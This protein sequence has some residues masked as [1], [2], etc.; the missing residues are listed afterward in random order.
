[1]SY[2]KRYAEYERTGKHRAARARRMRKIV[3]TAFFSICAV[4]IGCVIY[5][6]LS[7]V[8]VNKALLD[9]KRNCIMEN[10]KAAIDSYSKAIEL[11]SG[12]V[13]AYSNMANAYLSIDDKESAK[14]VLYEGWERTDN[15]ALLSNYRAVILNE[16]VADMNAKKTSLDTVSTILDVLESDKTNKDA[17]EL[18]YQ[19]YPRLCL[20]ASGDADTVFM[21]KLST[22]GKSDER[23]SSFTKYEELINRMVAVYEASPDERLREAITEY[24]I[25]WEDSFT[26]SISDVDSYIELLKKAESALG[27]TNEE[28]KS[29]KAC[30]DN[31][32]EVLGIFDDIF[33]QLDVGNVDELRNFIVSD[34][35]IKL[36]DLF[37]NKGETPQENTVYVPISR[38][39][40]VLNCKDGA[41]SYRFLNFEENPTTRG[42]ITVWANFFEDD[43]V[44]RNAI[45]YEPAAVGKDIYPHTKYSVTYLRSYITSGR[46]T[47]VAKMNYRLETEIEYKDGTVDKTIVGDWGGS[48]EWEMDIDTIESRIRA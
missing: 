1:M 5:S 13:S 48:D 25:P 17:I 20:N 14:K 26:M 3:L 22:E 35:Y 32:K 44:Q 30:L 31:S 8:Q 38:E 43:G 7:F 37:L 15:A 24:L 47:K 19:S 10:Y 2:N 6:N 40:I 12:A 36:R 45:S 11:D 33:K 16:T 18:L 4:V 21:T 42:V 34:E 41:W 46:S 27:G 23:G 28:V 39:A 9:G 29:I